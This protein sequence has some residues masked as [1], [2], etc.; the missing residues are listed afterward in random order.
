MDGLAG[1]VGKTK[2]LTILVM[3]VLLVATALEWY[4]LWGVLFL[5][6]SVAGIVTG[7]VFLVQ[8]IERERNPVL[9]WLLSLIWLVLA[10]MAI[11]QDVWI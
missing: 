5:Y 7:Q 6:W 4:W 8:T 1:S 2:W 3:L 9:F 11:V 10:V